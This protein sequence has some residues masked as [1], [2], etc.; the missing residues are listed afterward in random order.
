MINLYSKPFTEAFFL[1]F[2]QLTVAIFGDRADSGWLDSLPWR[3]ENMPDATVF[4]AE[5]NSRF[6]GYQAGYAMSHNRYYNWLS[7]VAPEYRRRGI[8]KRLMSHQHDWLEKSRYQSLETHIE[9]HNTPMIQLALDC[10]FSVSGF[11]EKDDYPYIIMH[12]RVQTHRDNE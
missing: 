2:R 3:L 10:R 8:A 7:G 12:K 1:D 9:Q 4:I 6:I 5:E 11:F